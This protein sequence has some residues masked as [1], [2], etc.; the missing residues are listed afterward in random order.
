MELKLKCTV[1]HGIG[2]NGGVREYNGY[3]KVELSEQEMNEMQG[4]IAKHDANNTS[5]DVAD[6]F[7]DIFARI[8]QESFDFKVYSLVLDTCVGWDE[9]VGNVREEDLIEEDIESGRFV[10]LYVN[11][12]GASRDPLIMNQWFVWMIEGIKALSY[13]E[14]VEYLT[15]RY[16]M[17]LPSLDEMEFETSY[18]IMEC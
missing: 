3:V 18:T 17:E 7:P 9:E 16:K 14:R 10:P 2:W 8:E 11:A 1:S 5:F 12:E 6:E 4:A 15:G 13:R